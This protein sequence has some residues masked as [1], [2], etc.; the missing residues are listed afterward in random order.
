MSCNKIQILLGGIHMNIPGTRIPITLV[1]AYARDSG[2]TFVDDLKEDFDL[3]DEQ[4][5]YAFN[6]ALFIVNS[7]NN[8]LK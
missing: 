5:E 1:L 8:K 2:A 7:L 6:H 4:I 3:T